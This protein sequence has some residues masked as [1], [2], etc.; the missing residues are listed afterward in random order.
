MEQS[1][2]YPSKL[3]IGSILLLIDNAYAGSTAI[4][5]AT[6]Q[7]GIE[8]FSQ[9]D[10]PAAKSIFEK[11]KQHNPNTPDIDYYL[12]RS[13][14][15]ARNFKSALTHLESSL[16]RDDSK[17]DT[18]YLIGIV[19]I[20][21]LA[22]VNIFKKASYANKSKKAWETAIQLDEDHLQARFALAS[23][24]INAPAIAGGDMQEAKHQIE[25]IAELHDGYGA[26][27]RAVFLEKEQKFAEAEAQFIFA[28]NNINNRAGPHFNLANFYLRRERFDDAWKSLQAYIAS[29]NKSWDDPSD[30]LVQLVSGNIQAELGNTDSAKQHLKLALNLNPGKTIREIIEERLSGL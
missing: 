27:A 28:T 24:Y 12:A 16:E 11:I 23:Y 4:S 9:R 3:L 5:T 25:T 17:A 29:N 22:D 10:F 18:H 30:L 8:L 26:M 1:M 15:K 13:Q 21:L 7:Q 6:L 20:S 2:R 14:I 19:Y